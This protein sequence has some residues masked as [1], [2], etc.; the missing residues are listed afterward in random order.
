MSNV[1]SCA[2]SPIVLDIPAATLEELRVRRSKR[3]S[4]PAGATDR[5]ILTTVE[6]VQRLGAIDPSSLAKA[7]CED[8]DRLQAEVED[9]Y[10]AFL[11]DPG[12][13]PMTYI[14]TDGRI[15]N[16]YR[17]WDGEGIQFE[18]S[19]DRVVA[20]LV[21]GAEKT[22]VASLL[23]LIPALENG[24][25]CTTC[26]GTRWFKLQNGEIVCPTCSG[27]GECPNA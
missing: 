18:T 8:M 2:M 16:D 17:T 25:P 27:R 14:T 9:E 21:V 24:V 20:S 22:G 15:L 11:L 4:P 6:M 23:N 7:F 5:P 13:G 26:N 10:D 3:K 1:H 12:M 19:L